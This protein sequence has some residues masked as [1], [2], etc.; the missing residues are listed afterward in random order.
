VILKNNLQIC[1]ACLS[2]VM[3]L[4]HLLEQLFLIEKDFV[5]DAKKHNVAL[6][7]LIQEKNSTVFVAKFEEEIVAMVTLQKLVSS[8]V[9]GYSGLIEDFV[10][11]EEF[12]HLGI[13]SHV[14]NALMQHAQ[15]HS[16][17]RLQL[18][19][20][21]HNELAQAF[22]LKKRFKKSNLRMWYLSLE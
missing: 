4:M 16:F 6:Q 12:K 9:G 10:V 18:A 5:F 2:D 21:E 22:Y 8:A 7:T 14:L 20:D 13:G 19:C 17:K 11:H 1:H 3:P 15:T